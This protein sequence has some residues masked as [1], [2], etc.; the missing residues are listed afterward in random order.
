MS[1]RR[2]WILATAVALSVAGAAWLG[3][4]R[5]AIGDA[6]ASRTLPT[7]AAIAPLAPPMSEDDARERDIAFYERRVEADRESAGDRAL[8][9]GLYLQ[10]ARATGDVTDYDRAERMAR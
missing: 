3:T 10:R 7:P 8:L 1:S 4:S 9:A 6:G 2:W 5:R